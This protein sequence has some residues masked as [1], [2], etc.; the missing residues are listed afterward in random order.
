MGKRP[1]V[2]RMVQFFETKPV[3]FH[4]PGH[5]HGSLSELPRAFRDVMKF[6]YTELNG[7]D[8]YHHPEEVIDEAQ[9]LLAKVYGADRSFFLVNGST[10]GNL[11]MVYA[12]CKEGDLVLVQRNAHK[13]IFHALELVG[14]SPVFLTPEWDGKTETPTHIS[15]LTLK[16]ALDMYPEAKALILTHPTYYGVTNPFMKKMIELAHLSNVP[17]LVDEAHGA[18][19]NATDTFPTSS[20]D[21]GADVVVQSAH[22]TL[23]ALTMGSYLHIQS[24]RVSSKKINTYLRMLQTSSP[25]YLLLASL[26][27]ARDYIDTFTQEDANSFT[28]IREQF[29][30]G[31]NLIKKLSVIEVEDP[32][33]LLLRV[34]GYSGFE[35]QRKLEEQGVYSELA[36]T[37][38]VL[39]ILPLLKRKHTFPFA[40]IRMSIKSAVEEL[41]KQ[42]AKKVHIDYIHD[43][44]AIS[45]LAKSY[46]EMDGCES[47][48]ILYTK[49]MGRISAGMVIPYLPGIPLFIRGEKITTNKLEMLADYLASGATIQGEHDLSRKLLLVFKEDNK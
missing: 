29:V 44:E 3:S 31:L 25:S 30:N 19:F 8:D 7:L 41:T 13:S 17:V 4:V 15:E 18:H 26:D 36:D 6:D 12:T 28:R 14:A 24:N 22:K 10:V 35:L 23:P 39:F 38:Q 27:D 37:T 5:K 9:L 47:E 45:R 16:S 20:L 21:L 49:A 33:K 48:W 1:I 42:P 32:L 2:E 40:D 46:K 34:N 11:A 43:L